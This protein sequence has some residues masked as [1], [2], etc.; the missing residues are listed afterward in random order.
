MRVAVLGAS[1]QLGSD[2]VRAFGDRGGYD[3][4]P[5]GHGDVEVTR[6]DQVRDVLRDAAADVVVNCAAYHRVD[7]CESQVDKTFQINSVGSVNVARACDER[8]ALCVFIS[9]DYVFDGAKGAP[10]VEEDVTSPLNVYGASKLAGEH[11]L[12]QGCSRWLVVRVAS[13]FGVAGASGKGGNFVEAILAKGAAGGPVQVVNDISMSPT[14]TWDAARGLELL[15][16]EEAEGLFHLTNG[17]STTWHGFASKILEQVG[18]NVAPE[19]IES[20]AQGAKARRPK[21]SSLGSE[22]ASD[23]VAGIMRDWDDALKHYLVEKG[24]I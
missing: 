19:P 6:A 2:L 22:R 9:S 21:N 8:G 12:R 17:G 15:V 23:T 1:G 4:V 11:L 13:L 16:R 14:Y 20:E 18:S 7:E 24:H 3:L 5:L 10:Y